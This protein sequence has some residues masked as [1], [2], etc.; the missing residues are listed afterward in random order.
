MASTNVDRVYEQIEKDF[1]ELYKNAGRKAALKAQ[2]DIKERADRFIREYYRYTPKVYK[3]R[4][5]A[6]FKLVE[7]VYE[8]TQLGD[9][10]MIEF[11][12]QYNPS[13]IK[14]VHQ[15]N[16][17]YHQ[18]G[19]NWIPRLD[20]E[21]SFDSQNNGIPDAT[22]ITEKFLSGIHPSGRIGDDGGV[23]DAQ[24]PDEKMQK[25]F[26]NELDDLVISYMDTALWDAVKTYF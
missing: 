24:S 6:L 25:F 4:K 13:K 16:S 21:F 8:E 2:D 7:R 23:M 11:G 26:D 19:T 5:K 14:G 9:G 1:M 18:T 17:W 3:Q 22:W 12:I 20:R 15:S 10:L